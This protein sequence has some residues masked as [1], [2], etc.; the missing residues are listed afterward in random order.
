MNYGED[1]DAPDGALGWG[2][3]LVSGSALPLLYSLYALD[4]DGGLVGAAASVAGGALAW[5]GGGLMLAGPGVACG[6]I[7]EDW[8]RALGAV[9]QLLGC[10][11]KVALS[12]AQLFAQA[13]ALDADVGAGFY[14]IPAFALL[15]MQGVPG[16]RSDVSARTA[17]AALSALV[18]GLVC[19]N[20]IYSDGRHSLRP[21]APLP[22]AS[23]G[24]YLLLLSNAAFAYSD[25]AR[26][27]A[28]E[29]HPFALRAA[30]F[31]GLAL[32][33]RV[34]SLLLAERQP[35]WLFVSQNVLLIH[36]S[37]LQTAAARRL[38]AGMRF[39]APLD[40]FRVEHPQ[41]ALM[42]WLGPV[43]AAALAFQWR[44]P[45]DA[46]GVVLALAAARAGVWSL[47]RFGGGQ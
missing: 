38:L 14:A 35:R 16:N 15:S 2:V 3:D 20:V 44:R 31:C 34:L 9:L 11:L 45:G 30:V 4:S 12:M 32:A 7:S 13:G 5:V 33:P 40:G 42:V 6:A 24:G 1:C 10:G 8:A 39:P 23:A 17:V 37:I 27:G 41:R 19:V 43:L 36:A 22:G 47:G 46:S 26:R 28:A 21:E 29:W 18:L 25:V